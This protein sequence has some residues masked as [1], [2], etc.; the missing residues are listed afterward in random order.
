MFAPHALLVWAVLSALFWRS[1]TL[2]IDLG[3]VS[4]FLVVALDAS[5]AAGG[6]MAAATTLKRAGTAAA[7]LLPT[8]GQRTPAAPPPTVPAETPWGDVGATASTEHRGSPEPAT[9]PTGARLPAVSFERVQFSY[10]GRPEVHV[11]DELSF[12][13]H[14]GET[15]ALLGPSGSGKSTVAALVSGWFAPDR[16]TVAL[17]GRT[18]SDF[19]AAGHPRGLL[20]L[21]PQAPSLFEGSLADNIAY[22]MPGADEATLILAASRAHA[23]GFI[24]A[25]PEG[26]ATAVVHDQQTLSGGQVQRIALARALLPQPRIL[27]LDEPTSALDAASQREVRRALLDMR[28]AQGA[29]ADGRTQTATL[30][31]THS[32]E[33]AN[34]LADRVVRLQ[35]QAGRGSRSVR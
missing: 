5:G 18:A 35:A 24:R 32:E 14:P 15:V 26:F 12:A 23:E 21:V 29:Q 30:L 2:D 19:A 8:A 20:A 16:G 34:L 10:P 1:A 22:G 3:V 11:L 31:I 27:I 7:A 25:L 17:F 28:Q 6:S 4:A 13:I 33:L 9:A